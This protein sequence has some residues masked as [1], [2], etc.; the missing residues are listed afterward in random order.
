[1]AHAELDTRK[2]EAEIG[3]LLAETV[4]LQVEARWFPFVAVAG[5]FGAALAL[6]KVLS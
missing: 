2:L 5:V 3:K 1:M 4:K 6:L